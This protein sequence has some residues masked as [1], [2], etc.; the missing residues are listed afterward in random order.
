[1]DIKE[2]LILQ[3]QMQPTDGSAI[4]LLNTEHTV[5]SISG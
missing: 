4:F 3:L 2:S 1:M 5:P